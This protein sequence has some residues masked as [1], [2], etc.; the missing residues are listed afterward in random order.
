M[1]DQNKELSDQIKKT[2]D[3]LPYWK[4]KLEAKLNVLPDHKLKV[5]DQTFN[6]F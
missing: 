3:I 6:P 1:S 2:P 5:S 4:K